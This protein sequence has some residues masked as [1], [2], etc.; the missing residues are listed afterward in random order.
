MKGE[1]TLMLE[2]IE[3]RKNEGKTIVDVLN[4]HIDFRNATPIKEYIAGL[5]ENGSKELFLNLSQVTFMDS[6]G[7]SVLL[8]GKRSAD[9][10]Q[11]D[12]SIFGL[13]GYVNNLIELTHLNR[14]I[15]I[16]I[17]EADALR[18]SRLKAKH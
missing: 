16:Y 17:S 6:A 3:V 7:L 10:T 12:F 13:Q 2:G 11:S 9:D 4:S 5:F 14:V 1:R 15:P 18:Q 8:V